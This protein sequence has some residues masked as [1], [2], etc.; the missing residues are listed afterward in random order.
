MIVFRREKKFK[1]EKT[2]TPSESPTQ[3]KTTEGELGDL[4]DRLKRPLSSHGTE[5]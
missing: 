4:E 3:T 2:K 5:C 1:K